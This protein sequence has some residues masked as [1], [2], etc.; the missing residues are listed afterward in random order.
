MTRGFTLLETLIALVIASITSLVLLQSIMAVARG[1]AGIDI[2]L[3]GA[4]ETEFSREAVS[5]ALAASVADYLDSPG[6]YTGSTTRIS[7]TTRR[8]VLTPHGLPTRFVLTLQPEAG[9]T[10]L[11]YQEVGQPAGDGNERTGPR[12]D[13][14]LTNGIVAMRFDAQDLEFRFAYQ[15]LSR[16]YD[17]EPAEA[18]DAWPP[19]AG[20]DP[21]YDYY[22]PP[23]TL[24]MIVDA[25]DQVL[26]AITSTGWNAP[27][28]RGRDLEEIL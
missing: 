3:A 1:T 22:R 4:L 21:W 13:S 23:P 12:E 6:A 25:E 24:V 8:P 26:W 2:A 10:A 15:S 27:P 7:G 17:R 18:L 5:D 19:E 11:V 28:I 9:G 14:T 20:F 16:L